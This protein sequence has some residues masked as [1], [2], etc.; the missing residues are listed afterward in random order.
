MKLLA[1]WQELTQGPVNITAEYAPKTGGTRFW[2]R[3]GD[4]GR[5]WFRTVWFD[6]EYDDETAQEYWR[7]YR[8]QF[9]EMSHP[10]PLLTKYRDKVYQVS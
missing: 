2:A 10:R 6:G 5:V 7:R 8:N 9:S 4:S 1:T 3:V